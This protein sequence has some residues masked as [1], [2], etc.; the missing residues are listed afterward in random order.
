MDFLYSFQTT[1]FSR[2]KT[3]EPGAD[4]DNREPVGV[5]E[6]IAEVWEK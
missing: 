4:Q 5:A 3:R 2:S 6:I 1:P